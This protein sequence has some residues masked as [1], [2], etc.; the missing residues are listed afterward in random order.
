[1]IQFL[2]SIGLAAIILLLPVLYA[3]A[4]TI[5]IAFFGD[6]VFVHA[7]ICDLFF[8]ICLPCILFLVKKMQ[9][10]NREGDSEGKEP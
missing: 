5:L 6:T 3:A 10:Q 4:L 8:L 1:M 7:S 9:K 2:L